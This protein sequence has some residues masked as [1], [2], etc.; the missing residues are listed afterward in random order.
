MALYD[1]YR[2]ICFLCSLFAISFAL[3]LVVPVAADSRKC[4]ANDSGISC[5]EKE[6][7]RANSGVATGKEAMITGYQKMY[8]ES[9]KEFSGKVITQSDVVKASEKCRNVSSSVNDCLSIQNEFNMRIQK[10][11]LQKQ[12]E[13]ERAMKIAGRIQSNKTRRRA[14]RQR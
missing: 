13:Q 12:A 10:A 14:I 4:T 6:S 11:R 8:L 5:A 7:S 2:S 1:Q 3:F 9:Q